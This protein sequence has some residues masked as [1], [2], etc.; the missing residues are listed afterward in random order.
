MVMVMD[1]IVQRVPKENE[2]ETLL[3]G[4]AEDGASACIRL[5][6]WHAWLLIQVPSLDWGGREENCPQHARNASMLKELLEDKMVTRDELLGKGGRR[7]KGQDELIRSISIVKGR[8][9]YGFFDPHVKQRFLRIEMMTAYALSGLRDVLSGYSYEDG[10]ATKRMPGVRV[11]LDPMTLRPVLL[12]GAPTET[13]NSNIDPVQQ[14]MVDIGL[15]GGQWVRVETG[16]SLP[17]DHHDRRTMCAY[18]WDTRELDRMDLDAVNM[19]APLRILSFDIEAAGRKGVFPQASEDPVI[20]IALQFEV[21]GTAAEQQPP[22]VLL[23]LKECDPIEGATVISFEDERELLRAFRYLASA[24]DVDVFTGYNVLSFE[25]PY[26]HDRACALSGVEDPRPQRPPFIIRG[27]APWG[28]FALGVSAADEFDSLSRVHGARLHIRETEFVSAQVGKRKRTKVIIPGCAVLDL[29]VALQNSQ[30]RLESYKL[31]SVAA[32]FLKDSK[33]D[34]PFTQI[35]PMWQAGPAERRELGVYCLKDAKLPLALNAK[36][37]MLVQTLEMARTTG[38]S[39]DDVLQR[40]MMLRVKSLLLRFALAESL[41]FPNMLSSNNDS[42]GQPQQSYTGATVLD[43][44]CGT[45]QAVGVLDFSSMYPSIIRA[46]NLCYSTIVLQKG[47]P[48]YWARRRTEEPAFDEAKGLLSVCGHTF[49]DQRHFKGLVPK[50]VEHLMNCRQRAKKALKEAKDPLAKQVCDAREKA[51][52]VSCNSMYGA[53]AS[54]SFILPLMA[55]AE[56]VTA[57]GRA[58][59]MRVKSIAEEMYPDGEVVYGDTDSVFVRMPL[60]KELLG[61]PIEG[62]AKVSEMCEAL[63]KRINGCMRPPKSIAFEK[64]L[65]SF[66]LLTKKRYAGL[67]YEAGFRFGVDEPSI[68]TKGLQ[69]VR[70]DGSPLV[71]N[72]VKE[73]IESILGTGNE[74]EAG[75]LVRRKLLDV[76][77]D[78][79]PLETYVIKKTLR[80]AMHD[81]CHPMTPEEIRSIREQLGRGGGGKGA[82][83]SYAEQDQAIHAKIPLPWRVKVRLP[84]VL[85]AW[86]LRLKDPG[87]APVP[88]A[89]FLY[90]FRGTLTR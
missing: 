28:D 60:E 15:H 19:V 20:Q 13:F 56:S 51:Y 25:F 72:L 67:K 34:I 17:M 53:L 49:V 40:G 58:D 66:L 76:V 46:H 8:S 43:P 30:H 73:V 16:A 12:P 85:L 9:I 45:H 23:S 54:Q 68:D 69:S 71:R 10:G 89:L 26:L 62:V 57:L 74:V 88:G 37:N 80:K 3:L 24:F 27:A 41:F 39:F 31:D 32:Y 2:T 44:V 75:A 18:E 70:R 82:E 33:V 35:T 47:S 21:Y 81:C 29:F 65:W 22:P 14:L 61:N 90:F 86:R 84:H 1:V 50:I 7:K 55:I 4:R 5:N 36:L 77:E 42:G 48:F 11:A 6:G 52:K 59:I 78:R 87:S 83:L 63:V 38:I 79:L 64:V